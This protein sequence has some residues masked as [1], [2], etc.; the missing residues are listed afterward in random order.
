MAAP[1]PATY[2]LL[3]AEDPGWVALYFLF[4]TA[5]HQAAALLV[6][7]PLAPVLGRRLAPVA[8]YVMGGVLTKHLI[9]V[10]NKLSEAET[11]THTLFFLSL[12]AAHHLSC[13]PSLP[14]TMVLCFNNVT[15]HNAMPGCS[16]GLCGW[17]WEGV[18]VWMG[19]LG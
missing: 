14:V 9:I 10:P 8:R 13:H 5:L 7:N 12:P 3:L 18:D 16:T 4:D 17:R 6:S 2:N 15:E 1:S 19:A 11:I